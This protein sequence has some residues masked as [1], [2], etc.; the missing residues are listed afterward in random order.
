MDKNI[1]GN[2]NMDMDNN[3][4]H[5][6]TITNPDHNLLPSN[7]SPLL[8]TSYPPTAPLSQA[9]HQGHDNRTPSVTSASH[10]LLT[11]I[12]VVQYHHPSITKVDNI[13]MVTT[14]LVHIHPPTTHRT[15]VPTLFNQNTF[16][17]RN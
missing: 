10:A 7:A 13:I 14:T 1:T 9:R 2:N 3:N 17:L 15:L 6:E 11:S 16:Q 8:Q 5:S 4:S 12:T